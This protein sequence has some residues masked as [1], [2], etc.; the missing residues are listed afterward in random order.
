MNLPQGDLRLLDSAAARR[1][2]SS[3]IPAR[4]AFVWSDGTPRVI[5]TWFVWTG[6]EIVMCTFLAGPGVRH[7]ARRVDVLRENPHV[8][9]TIDTEDAVPD[10]LL[11][12]GW[13]VV[14]EVDGLAAEHIAAARRYLGEEGAASFAAS[15]QQPGIRT[16]RIGVRPSWVGLLDFE[17]RLPSPR[18]GILRPSS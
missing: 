16:A 4:L 11:I 8:A 9:I 2:L 14:T 17:T 6:T 5:P 3:S 15:G 12:R 7:P 13:A 18:G 1:L 10:V